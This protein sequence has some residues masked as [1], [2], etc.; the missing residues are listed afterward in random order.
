MVA[1]ISC[2]K[3]ES[4]SDIEVIYLRY[5]Y[6]D[7][8]YYRKI[9]LINKEY[10]KS[11]PRKYEQD[12]DYQFVSSL[13]DDSIVIFLEECNRNGFLTWDEEYLP[14]YPSFNS[15]WWWITIQYSDA[16]EKKMCGHGLY[17]DTWDEVRNALKALTGDSTT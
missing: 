13:E 16:S 2:Q 5:A 11:G 3:S 8:N 10:W 1:M 17:P 7:N 4:D 6:E 15:N 14:D 12:V 9:D